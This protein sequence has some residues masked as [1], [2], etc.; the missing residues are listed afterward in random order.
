MY[1]FRVK[2]TNRNWITAFCAMFA[3]AAAFWVASAF[4]IWL[5]AVLH[6]GIMVF[7]LLGVLIIERYGLSSYEY[8]INDNTGDYDFVVIKTS[9][10]RSNVV[11]RMSLSRAKGFTKVRKREKITPA[12]KRKFDYTGTLFPSEYWLLSFPDEGAVLK[13]EPDA[14]MASLIMKIAGLENGDAAEKKGEIYG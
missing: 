7:L 11:C 12:E 6:A 13:I 9:G 2:P 14:G 1:S 4:G 3:L 8:V 5:R 10:S